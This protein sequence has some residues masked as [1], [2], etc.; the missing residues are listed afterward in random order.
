M[1]QTTFLLEGRNDVLAVALPYAR[2]L[3]FC[4]PDSGMP[5]DGDLGPLHGRFTSDR[6]T[7]RIIHALWDSLGTSERGCTL[8]ADG[9]VLGLASRLM[10]LA[11]VRDPDPRHGRLTA[12]Q[13]GRVRDYVQDHLHEAIDL[14]SLAGA[15]DLSVFHFARCFKATT[16]TTPH[17]Y[18]MTMRA[19]RAAAML[20]QPG[21]TIS[22]VA[23]ECGYASS[24]H[25]STAFR[26]AMGLTP[27]DF[28]RRSV[29]ARADDEP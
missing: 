28:R 1:C 9:L 21:A 8:A 14:D 26:S 16:G 4:G 6:Q 25:F 13:F 5:R 7:V 12:W 18:V 15:L 19:E 23:M 17:R 2:L 20:A 3:S 10:A 24:Q 27:S 29:P 11:R 22:R